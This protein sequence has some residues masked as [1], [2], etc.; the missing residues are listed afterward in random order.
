MPLAMLAVLLLAYTPEQF[1]ALLQQAFYPLLFAVFVIASLGAPIPEDIPLIAAGVILRTHPEVASWP[2]TIIVS[3]IGIMS[4]DVIL[5]SL[6]R[7]WGPEVF[8]HKSVAWLITPRRLAMMTDKFHQ[9]GVWMC[10]FG[11]FMVG[12]RAVMCLTAGVT[13]FKFWKFFLADFAGALL[14]APFFIVI[15]YVFAGMLDQAKHYLVNAQYIFIGLII[16]VGIVIWRLEVRKMRKQR[17]EDERFAV[18]QAAGGEP[19]VA[20]DEPKPAPRN[21]STLLAPKSVKPEADAV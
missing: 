4:G 16:V 20:P 10:F 17:A 5:Y 11:R 6:G 2:L 9:Y 18:E 7:R 1:I 8:K 3:L 12:V 21:A 14:S 19:R 13:K 15:G